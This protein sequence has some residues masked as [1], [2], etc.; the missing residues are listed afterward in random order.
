MAGHFGG[1][2]FTAGLVLATHDKELRE[3]LQSAD[4][5]NERQLGQ[6]L[7]RIEGCVID[8]FVVRRAA[9][10]RHWQVVVVVV[11]ND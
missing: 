8:G 6:L 11:R 3:A 7:K 2:P 1:M 10:R 4:V 9:R 5:D